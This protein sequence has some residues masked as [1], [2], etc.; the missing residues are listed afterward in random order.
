MIKNSKDYK[1]MPIGK[2][3]R[4]EDF[5][6]PPEKLVLPEENVK[7]TISLSRKSV[8]FFKKQA[9]LHHMKYQKMIRRLVDRYVVLY[10]K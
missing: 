4:I 9:T 6:P 7:V 3:Q 8:D 2:M 1:D 5:L 10:S